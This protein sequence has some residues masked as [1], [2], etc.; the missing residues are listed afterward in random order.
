MVITK[1]G[2]ACAD[3]ESDML[4]DDG[5]ASVSAPACAYQYHKMAFLAHHACY[6][7]C[8]CL[9]RGSSC[10]ESLPYLIQVLHPMHGI[11]KSCLRASQANSTPEHMSHRVQGPERDPSMQSQVHVLNCAVIIHKIVPRSCLEAGRLG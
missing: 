7:Y 2:L 8:Y 5:P 4:Y 9:S 1:N 10:A 11:L 6:I 3:S